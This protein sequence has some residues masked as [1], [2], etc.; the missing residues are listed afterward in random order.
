MKARWLGA[1]IAF[2]A[3]GGCDTT[4][5]YVTATPDLAGMASPA[6]ACTPNAKECVSSTLARVCPADGTGWLSVPCPQGQTCTNG[7]CAL[8]VTTVPCT[9][10]DNFCV[11]STTALI[12]N[13]NFMGFKMKACPSGTQ[14]VGQGDCL[15][16][17]C[18]VGSS[19]CEGVQVRNCTADGSSFTMPSP[20]PTGQACSQQAGNTC[21]PAACTPGNCSFVCG[22]KASDPNSSDSGFF[23]TCQDTQL[24]FRWVSLACQTPKTCS[25]T[26]ACTA[27][28]LADACTSQCTPGEIRCADQMTNGASIGTQTQ[29]WCP[30]YRSPA[31]AACRAIYAA[32][33]RSWQAP[34]R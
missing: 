14:C 7:D 6:P 34:S 13:S 16:A 29:S 1:A 33:S 25:P 28:A 17:S 31:M 3:V 32:H 8:D 27:M 11:N 12:C 20:C 5:T 19:L 18:I 4:N 22:D 30:P 10:A 15:G 2:A 24:G 23:S 21:A 9:Q 26:A